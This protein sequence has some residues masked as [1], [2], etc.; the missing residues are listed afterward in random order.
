MFLLD[1]NVLIDAHRDYYPLDR[2]PPFWAWLVTHG[3]AGMIK[4][5]DAIYR[6]LL[7]GG[8]ELREW[9]HE[10]GTQSALRLSEDPAVSHIQQAVELGYASDLTDIELESIGRD[11]FLIAHCLVDSA[12]RTIVTTEV[13]RPSRQ[14]ANR[15]LPD[16][17]ADLGL[18]CINTYELIRVLDFRI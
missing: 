1:A 13:S 5:P 9:A 17:C 18:V 8:D 3:E 14:R 12:N 16:V 10:P 4:I 7:A 6:E 15:H 11:P 2:V